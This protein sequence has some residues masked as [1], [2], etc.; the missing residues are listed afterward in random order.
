M[1]GALLA[2][3][4]GIALVDSL[5]PSLFVAQF[6][7]LTTPRPVPRIL[8][9]IAGVLLANFG[10]GLLVLAGLRRV[11]AGALA[12]VS[13]DVANAG[14]LLLGTA[15][16]VF[17]LW[18]RAQ[19]KPATEAKRPR[20]L[21]AISAFGLGVVVMGN[22]LTTAVPYFVALERITEAGLGLAG[23]LLALGLYNLVFAAPLFAFLAL[24][25]VYRGRFTSQLDRVN[26][27][28]L[29]W[30]PR[31]VKYGS[32]ALG[33]GLVTFAGAALVLA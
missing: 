25:V 19:P 27:W 17:G 11:L 9:Y 14:L 20:S 8:A 1:T 3:V 2:A 12:A 32:I 4:V 31:I 13:A 26:R 16:L 10:G 21:R 5:N 28:V 23:N 15:V 18:Y 30:T 6:Y 22:E 33:G 7:L 24:A 29:R